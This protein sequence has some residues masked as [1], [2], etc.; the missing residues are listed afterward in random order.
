M[1]GARASAE[2]RWH[3]AL[4]EDEREEEKDIERDNEPECATKRKKLLREEKRINRRLLAQTRKEKRALLK[5]LEKRDAK[6]GA[7][8]ALGQARVVKVRCGSQ[9]EEEQRLK[10]KERAEIERMYPAWH[11]RLNLFLTREAEE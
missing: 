7:R 6:R 5:L 9:W 11:E 8:L 2:R 4:A 1:P 3:I 10:R